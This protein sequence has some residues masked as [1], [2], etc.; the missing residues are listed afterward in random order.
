MCSTDVDGGSGDDFTDS[1]VRRSFPRTRVH[2]CEECGRVLSRG[3]KHAYVHGKWEGAMFSFRICLDCK[4]WGEAFRVA[5][6]KAE[7]YVCNPELGTL[8][9]AIAEFTEEHLGY[10]PV[11]EKPRRRY[12]ASA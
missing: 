9:D 11:P 3:E 7:H 1:E 4:A 10:A 8:W 6:K 12:G 5:H 2:F